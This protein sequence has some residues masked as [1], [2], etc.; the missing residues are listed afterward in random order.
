MKGEP[1]SDDDNV[2]RLCTSQNINPS[3]ESPSP[4]AFILRSQDEYVSVKWLEFFGTL[5]RE[6]QLEEVR[7]ALASKMTVRSSARLG[8]LNVAIAKARVERDVSA[9]VVIAFLHR[10]DEP[11]PDPSHSGIFFSRGD[12]QLAI[13]TALAEAVKSML[14]AVAS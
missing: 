1:I 7:R 2:T 10:P 5:S 8:L 14:P 3:D 9:D 13:A 4:A 12:A 11:R 6:G